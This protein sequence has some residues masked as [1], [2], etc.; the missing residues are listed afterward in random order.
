MFIWNHLC[1][2]I[3]FITCVFTYYSL[4]DLLNLP[5]AVENCPAILTLQIF[6]KMM[7][8]CAGV[9]DIVV[10][11]PNN[12]TLNFNVSRTE[13]DLPD[14][15]VIFLNDTLA[16]HRLVLS[17]VIAPVSIPQ[18]SLS[19]GDKLSR[20]SEMDL[21]QWSSIFAVVI[22]SFIG[23]VVVFAVYLCIK[24]RS[25]TGASA[26]AAQSSAN[27]AETAMLN[28]QSGNTASK[29]PETKQHKSISAKSCLCLFVT[30][31]IVYSIVF[32]FSL[33]LVILYFTHHSLMGG[34][35]GMANFSSQLQRE[36]NASFHRVQLHESQEE[37]RL[38]RSVDSR[39][40]AC[41]HHLQQQ[42]RQFL[43]SY[44]RSVTELLS[45]V[46]QKGGAIETLAGQSIVQNTS[47]YTE[48]IELFLQDCN[49][50]VQSIVDRFSSHFMIHVKEVAR[51]S[52]LDFPREVFLTQEG[53]PADR[54]Y[55]SSNQLA[56][57]L[58]WLQVD[59]TDELLSVSDT[60]AAR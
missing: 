36:L 43:H 33:T 53:D 32:T 26:E 13:D 42:N 30:L 39:M 57:F 12:F 14:I 4:I 31:Y 50:T 45:H 35:S 44:H 6:N 25:T 8:A 54:K 29:T 21:V 20:F 23:L 56:R 47:I 3:S 16:S 17:S 40:Q 19:A 46:F 10:A 11:C 37:V 52:W 28:N 5:G 15:F 34:V 55:M 7:S 51:N 24:H 48:E 18:S 49:K 2:L 38:F 1:G 60:V 22:L 58:R 27:H 59:K 9:Y 41:A